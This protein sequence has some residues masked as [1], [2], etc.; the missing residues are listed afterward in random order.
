VNLEILAPMARE[1][2]LEEK[3]A[4]LSSAAAYPGGVHT[5]GSRETHMSWVFL[6]GD[7]V[8]KLKKPVRFPYLDFSTLAR[9]EAACRAELELNRRLAP[10]IYLD[11]VP[12][13]INP[14]GLAV[15]QP[16]APIDWL[17]VMRRL[18]DERMLDHVILG[19]CLEAR[20]LER[21]ATT[22]TQFYQRARPA[23]IT[24]SAHLAGW[25][26]SLAYNRR[27]LLDP[28]SSRPAGLVRRIDRV[29][30]EFLDRHATVFADLV[31]ARRIVEAHGDLRP[32]HIWLGGTVKIID[33]LEFNPRLR[34]LDPF[35]EVAYL[36][37]ECERLGAR[38]AGEY[39]KRR[40]EAT[41]R[42]G[43]S[44]PLFAFYRCHRATLRAR[45]AIAHLLEP[46]PRTPEKWPNLARA[47]LDLAKADAIRI[48]HSLRRPEDR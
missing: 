31:R 9:R 25:A 45:L 44:E 37:L 2:T 14:N 29:Q 7:R 36:A 33:C 23:F 15:D 21:I 40:I 48:E 5:V 41:L 22:L 12:L 27:V 6:A 20:Q 35:E 46:N 8:Y 3:V 1:P 43:R 18:D 24:A 16:G 32:E 26:K 10:G 30:R 28:R 38:W 47:Y 34:M 42:D 17:V 11:V 39:L 13:S 19:G 4:F